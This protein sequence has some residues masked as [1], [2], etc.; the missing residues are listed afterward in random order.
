VTDAAS[1]AGTNMTEFMF[2]GNLVYHK[3]GKCVD[4]NG[5]LGGSALVMID[6]VKNLIQGAKFS[7]EEALKMATSYPAKAIQVD[8]RY[9]HIKPGYI[10][11]LTYFDENFKVKGTISKGILERY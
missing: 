4:A 10:A 8:S 9:G 11:D 5:T 7:Y 2:E 1:P 6:G 3:D